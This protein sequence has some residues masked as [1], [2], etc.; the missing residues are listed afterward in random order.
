LGY[1]KT[2]LR[3]EEEVSMSEESMEGKY[4][5]ETNS[6]QLK[7]EEEMIEEAGRDLRVHIYLP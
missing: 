5:E 6:R 7:N 4:G 3:K 2:D 1:R